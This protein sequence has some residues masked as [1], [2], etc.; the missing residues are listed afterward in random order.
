LNTLQQNACQNLRM[1]DNSQQQIHKFSFI[2]ELDIVVN[3][4]LAIVIKP[5]ANSQQH[6][7]LK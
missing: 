2:S 3:L 1:T 5:T 6:Q 4:L 7:A